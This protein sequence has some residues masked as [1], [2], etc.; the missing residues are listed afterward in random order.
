MS[1]V[2][3]SLLPMFSPWLTVRSS[4]DVPI[5]DE[6][7]S[8]LVLREKPKPR[9]LLHQHL[10]QVSIRWT[11]ESRKSER[12]SEESERPR[13][14]IG[15]TQMKHSRDSSEESK[16]LTCQGQS[17]NFDFF[18]PT[19]RPCPRRGRTPQSAM[20]RNIKCFIF[21]FDRI[22]Y[23]VNASPW[24]EDLACCLCKIHL[25]LPRL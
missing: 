21:Y 6:N 4:E 18:P 14:R 17:P 10:G 19:I 23:W 20:S 3:T 24:S 25:F 1:N 22:F 8:A 12:P 5:R 16:R 2:W 7:T 11:L 9:R 13:W 15:E